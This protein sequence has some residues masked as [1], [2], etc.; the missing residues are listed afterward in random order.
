VVSERK[1]ETRVKENMREREKERDCF[2]KRILK[3]RERE[4]ERRC[5]SVFERRIG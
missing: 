3:E 5:G 4:R 2:W 1:L